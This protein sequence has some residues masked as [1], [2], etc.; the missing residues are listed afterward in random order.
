M[1]QPTALA[2]LYDDV[3]ACRLLPAPRRVPRA[4]WSREA[5]RLSRLHLLGASRARLRRPQRPRPRLRSRPRSPRQQP[6]RP[7]LHRRRLRQVHVSHPAPP[8]LRLPAHGHRPRRRT[9]PSTISG[10]PPP[11]A[12]PHPTTN[13]SPPSSP[14]APDSLSAN[15][16]PCPTSKSS[17]PSANS[18]SMPTWRQRRARTPAH[19]PCAKSPTS[20]PTPPNT[21]CPTASPCS[22]P[23]TPPTRT[24]PP[25]SSP[26]PCSKLSLPAPAS[27][28]WHSG[29]FAGKIMPVTPVQQTQPQV[30]PPMP[31]PGQGSFG[32]HLASLDG[33]RAFSILL[34]F[35]CHGAMAGG[36]VNSHTSTSAG[37]AL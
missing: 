3:V 13:R 33:L 11:S 12:A 35:I 5:P 8:R 19:A 7:S 30:H 17:S 36:H 6:H 26:S 14:T 1:N 15:S 2:I 34:V 18:P 22:P 24:P 28:R 31:L 20:S 29:A 16:P 4:H 37:S 25:A 23:T 10:S 9:P 32:N 21:P 27:L